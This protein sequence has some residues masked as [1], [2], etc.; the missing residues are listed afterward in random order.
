MYIKDFFFGYLGLLTSAN[1]FLVCSI[2]FCEAVAIYGIIMS[3]V[4]S[5]NVAVSLGFC[6]FQPI[7]ESLFT[8]F[9]SLTYAYHYLMTLI[10]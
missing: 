2:I 7:G 10:K 8:L 3:I 6:Q 5:N 1:L 9:A 4:L